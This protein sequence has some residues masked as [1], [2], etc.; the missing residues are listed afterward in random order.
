MCWYSLNNNIRFSRMNN[1]YSNKKRQAVN[2][3]INY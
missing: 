1:I 3:I 2:T